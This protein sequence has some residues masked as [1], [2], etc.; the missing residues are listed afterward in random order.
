M[1]EAG[2]REGEK[3][4]EQYLSKKCEKRKGWKGDVDLQS[5]HVPGH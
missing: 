2:A 4:G 1:G 3:E 5:K